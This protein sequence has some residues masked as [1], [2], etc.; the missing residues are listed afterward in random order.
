MQFLR[1]V[2]SIVRLFVILASGLRIAIRTHSKCVMC[3]RRADRQTCVMPMKARTQ[4]F[5]EHR[6][7]IPAGK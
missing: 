5:T 6:I 2:L 3:A 7:I 1:N 4:I